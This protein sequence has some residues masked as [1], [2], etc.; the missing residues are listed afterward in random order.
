MCRRGSCGGSAAG[1]ERWHAAPVP[2]AWLSSLK[3]CLPVA[4]TYW[5]GS[6][7]EGEA[8]I[9]FQAHLRSG[10]GGGGDR[11]SSNAR[12]A[13]TQVHAWIVRAHIAIDHIRYLDSIFLCIKKWPSHSHELAR[14]AANRAAP[15]APVG[16]SCA[17]EA[18]SAAPSS[19]KTHGALRRGRP[20]ANVAGDRSAAT[21]RAAAEARAPH[22]R[23]R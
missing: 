7:G 1:R 18:A 11:G 2:R 4:C 9:A 19:F 23:V 16:P 8:C 22:H 3:H 14:S 13:R 5:R 20:D 10:S 6:V 15:A 17:G 21:A 12:T